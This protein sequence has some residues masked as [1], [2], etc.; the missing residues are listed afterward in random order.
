MAA[1]PKLTKAERYKIR[2]VAFLH[3]ELQIFIA[4]IDKIENIV[5][6]SIVGVATALMWRIE[7]NEPLRKW[8][9]WIPLVIWLFYFVKYLAL[10]RNIK[11]VDHYIKGIEKEILKDEK[12]W[13]QSYHDPVFQSE[14]LGARWQG[15][16]ESIKA[17]VL[18]RI[19]MR[20]PRYLYWV[21]TL[22]AVLALPLLN[23]MVPIGRGH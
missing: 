7:I 10:A 12:G 22:V 15:V 4:S 23:A 21:L 19:R 20:W 6:I 17:K 3:R 18:R 2:E 14:A 16:A 5:G 13:V 8:I 11:L 1:S 9:S